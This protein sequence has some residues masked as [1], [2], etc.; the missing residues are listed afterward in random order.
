AAICAHLEP[1]IAD[2]VRFAFITGWRIASEVLSLEWR[3]VDFQA[4]E[5]R[6][7]PGTTKNR[8]GRVF[9]LTTALRDLLK[10]RKVEH[11]RLKKAGH[12]LP[13]VFWRMIAEGRGGPKKPQL[14]VRFD[15]Q[16]KLACRAA[17]LPGR[18]P[19]DLRR[20]A[21]RTF[22]RKGISTHVA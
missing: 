3:Q 5:I 20:S 22:V 11:D 7:F 19:H 14:I 1:E 2:I 18:I 15:K 21:I 10:A 9:P 13:N 12:I 16:W 6:L 17:G 8:E 4:G